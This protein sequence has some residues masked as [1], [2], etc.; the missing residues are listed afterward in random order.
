MGK[1]C[2][3]ISPFLPRADDAGH[4]KRTFESCQMLADLGYELTLMHLAFEGNWY[5]RKQSIDSEELRSCGITKYFEFYADALVGRAPLSGAKVQRLD[6]WWD[7]QFEAF[8]INHLRRNFY[9]GVII[10]NIWLSKAFDFFP[11]FTIKLVETHDLFSERSSQFEHIGAVSDFYSCSESDEIFG[12][13][14]SHVAIAIKSDDASWI[15]SRV[16]NIDVVTVSPRPASL[17][18]RLRTD[19]Q[20]QNK[21][22][23][24]FIGSAHLFNLHCL[25]AFLKLLKS[26]LLRNPLSLEVLLAGNVCDKINSEDFPFIKKLGYVSSVEDFYSSVDFIF[27]PLDY[28]TGLKLKVAEAIEY[29]VPILSTEHSAAGI[30]LN[31]ELISSDK[32]SLVADVMSV[33][34]NR[35]PYPEY[36][37]RVQASKLSTLESYKRS[38]HT[39]SGVLSK[40]SKHF[41]L[42]YQQLL[43]PPNHP[44]YAVAI[45]TVRLFS[46]QGRVTLLV[47]KSAASHVSKIVNTMPAN[48]GFM[49]VTL[50]KDEQGVLGFHELCDKESSFLVESVF[51]TSR[52]D[53]RFP[54]GR[55][56]LYDGRLQ[57]DDN[58][59]SFRDKSGTTNIK[60]QDKI[61]LPLFNNSLNWDSNVMRPLR[62]GKLNNVSIFLKL[63]NERAFA[64]SDYLR[65]FYPNVNLLS[66]S[67]EA[68]LLNLIP[69]WLNAGKIG[70]TVAVL[71]TSNYVVNCVTEYLKFFGHKVILFQNLKSIIFI[72]QSDCLTNINSHD[73]EQNL[74]KKSLSLINKYLSFCI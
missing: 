43:M 42:D 22:V 51:I 10:H 46:G 44:L 59:L 47:E 50:V 34:F 38:M 63:K 64:L 9:D 48:V 53:L 71:T 73:Y 72:D 40:R 69:L 6:E 37:V 33:A 60:D 61:I 3:V 65:I 24:G 39:L 8:L 36:L 68:E 21:V 30:A 45:S 32:R 4:R 2:L 35:P 12:F 41:V 13:K 27:S 16:Q 5:F 55:V 20:S 29:G 74:T 23:F 57:G 19:Y 67:S 49:P 1:S 11:H 26:E 28:G 58:F 18:K 17:P 66:Y 14:R 52:K 70:N 62:G 31:K 54:L 25:Q 56:E 7:P 15:K